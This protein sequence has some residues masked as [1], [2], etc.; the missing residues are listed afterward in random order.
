MWQMSMVRWTCNATSWNEKKCIVEETGNGCIREMIRRMDCADVTMWKQW[1]WLGETDKVSVYHVPVENRT[2]NLMDIKTKQQNYTHTIVQHGKLA[3]RSDRFNEKVVW[4]HPKAKVN[5]LWVIFSNILFF[6]D[7][8]NVSLVLS[9][10]WAIGL[11]C[12]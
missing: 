7:G 8:C 10:R 4:F 2:W 12:L 11:R 3:S 1:E 5:K 6:K 9:S